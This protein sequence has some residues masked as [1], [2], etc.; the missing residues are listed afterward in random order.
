M[1]GYARKINGKERRKELKKNYYQGEL[2][3]S[4]N[5]PSLKISKGDAVRK[6]SKTRLFRISRAH[7]RLKSCSFFSLYSRNSI[8]FF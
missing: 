8:F 3:F 5:R 6:V 1:S 7:D 2:G 4:G